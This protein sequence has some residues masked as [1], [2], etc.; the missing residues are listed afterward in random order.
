M[1]FAAPEKA[2]KSGGGS[3]FQGFNPK[4]ALKDIDASADVFEYVGD[5]FIS[6]VGFDELC[7]YHRYQ[8]LEN[9]LKKHEKRGED[10]WTPI[11][12][13]AL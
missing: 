11:F 13:Y 3:A 8:T 7:N 1:L 10:R 4:T 6:L 9:Y 12:S 2:E 5:A